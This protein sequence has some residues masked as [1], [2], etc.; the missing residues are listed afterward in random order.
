LAVEESAGD[1]QNIFTRIQNAWNM[2]KY[3]LQPT[4]QPTK[5]T[6]QLWLFGKSCREILSSLVDHMGR[7]SRAT[8]TFHCGSGDKIN[9][10]ND[11][12]EP[13]VQTILITFHSLHACA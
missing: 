7:R 8:F 11:P 13:R 6:P 10:P 12:N 2:L 3:C 4:K 1:A 9:D 5:M